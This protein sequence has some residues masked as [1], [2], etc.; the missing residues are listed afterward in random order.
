MLRADPFAMADHVADSVRVRVC[1]FS[2]L[3]F[4]AMLYAL[5]CRFKTV[6]PVL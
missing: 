5:V 3:T 4:F 2:E 1:R 6:G